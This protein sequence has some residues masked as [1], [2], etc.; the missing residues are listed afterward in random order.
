MQVALLGA[1]GVVGYF[2]KEMRDEDNISNPDPYDIGYFGRHEFFLYTTSVGVVIAILSLVGSF[3]GL[4]EKKG[5]TLAV[6]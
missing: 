4:L 5:G 2:L 3:I 6:S 1:T